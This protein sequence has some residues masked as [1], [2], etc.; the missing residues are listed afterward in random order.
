VFVVV[1]KSATHELLIWKIGNVSL[2]VKLVW[3]GL[4]SLN[5]KHII[6]RNT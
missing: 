6:R 3:S 4:V 2:V 1:D 5:M